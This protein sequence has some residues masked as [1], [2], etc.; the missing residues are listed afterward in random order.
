MVRGKTAVE[1][2]N[3]LMPDLTVTEEQL[4]LLRIRKKALDETLVYLDIGNVEKAVGAI[5]IY[6]WAR[7]M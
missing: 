1:F 4:M 5:R 2:M 3:D 6:D 7:S